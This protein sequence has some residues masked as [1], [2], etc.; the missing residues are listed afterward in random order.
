[1][2]VAGALV[3]FLAV[4]ASGERD[5]S[6]GSFM[7]AVLFGSLALSDGRSVPNLI[8]ALG[9]RPVLFVSPD[10]RSGFS[11]SRTVRD[12]FAGGWV[13]RRLAGG[14]VA[15]CGHVVPFPVPVRGLVGRPGRVPEA[16]N[17]W[18]SRQWALRPCGRV[19][20]RSGQRRLMA[21]LEKPTVRL[22][23]QFGPDSDGGAAA[24]DLPASGLGLKAVD[25]SLDSQHLS[26]G[27][28]FADLVWGAAP[29]VPH[30]IDLDA[31]LA[32]HGGILLARELRRRKS[33]L[34]R[35]FLAG[36]L[37]RILPGVYVH[38]DGATELE[39]RLRAV[40]AR[41]P[42]ATISGSAAARLTNWPK[43]EVHEVEVVVTNRRVPQPGFRFIRRRVPPELVTR[44]S[45]IAVVSPALLAVDSACTDNGERID[46]LLR[47]HWPLDVIDDAFRATRGRRGNPK[48]RRVL[49]RSRTQPWSQAER[50]LHDILDRHRLGGWTANLAVTSCGHRYFLDVG[51]EAQKVAIEVD[52]FEFHGTRSAFE[53][54][55][56][57]GNDL[58]QDGWRVLHLTAMALGDERR[59]IRRV[60][61]VLRSPPLQVTR[62][63]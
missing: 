61:D 9:L 39:T 38:P 44:R 30:M 27:R 35:W 57:R 51:F 24:G 3:A 55:R 52:G 16:G 19:M 60:R 63:R 28:E 5:I 13:S 54:D 17:C 62:G 1:M 53:Y 12:R 20:G 58:V 10:P 43:E 21:H 46:D 48:R 23:R 32:C 59:L 15:V 18:S 36:R 33:S 25:D 37:A 42:D 34:S 11:Q 6:A 29:I 41:I 40:A 45:G 49:L 14:L 56:E 4:S 26:T 50:R 8:R 2:R 22:W 31:L 7:R 47:G